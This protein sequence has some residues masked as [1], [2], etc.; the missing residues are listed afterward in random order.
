MKFCPECGAKNDGFKF[1]SNCGKEIIITNPTI[2][3]INLQSNTTDSSS[4]VNLKK[5]PIKDSTSYKNIF[6]LIFFLNVVI[7]FFI[8]VHP[9]AILMGISSE[10][11]YNKSAEIFISIL[12]LFN[13]IGVFNFYKN[14]IITSTLI[15]SVLYFI[16]L[17][18]FTSSY[19]Y[20]DVNFVHHLNTMSLIFSIGLICLNL[21]VIFINFTS[22][23]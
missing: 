15:L 4:L 22:K 2:P 11:Y 10:Y 3:K 8:I 6:N 9:G 20:F 13:V 21:Y 12:S 17:Y 7:P 23:D 16:G 5:E 18:M 1:C 19:L 14:K